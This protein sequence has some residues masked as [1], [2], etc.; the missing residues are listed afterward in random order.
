VT[1][2][3]VGMMDPNPLVA[4]RGIRFLKEKGIAITSG[5]LAAECLAINRPFVQWISHGT[6]WVIMKAGLSLDGRIAARSGNAGWI[7]N[8]ASRR[9]VHQLR[10]QVDAILIGIGTAINDDPSLTTR[11]PGR[12][13]RDPLRVVLDR[14]LRLSPGARMLR[15][16]SNV[17]TL[18]CCGP[19]P[20]PGRW[21]A[22]TEAGAEVVPLA[23]AGDGELDLRQVLVE[24]GRRQI[25]SLL[26]EG[27]SRIHGAFWSQKLVH[28]V[29]LF[30]GP[31]I[32]GADG[33]PLLTPL[34]IDQV[35]Q[36]PRLHHIRH[37][38]FGDDLMIEGL[39]V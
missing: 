23:L 34:A 11:L 3:V 8:A 9:H 27:G 12:G 17:G 2:V 29:N 15:Q 14:D 30:Y 5:V 31:L 24:L 32:L 21:Q 7:T 19:Q 35:E 10:D 1:R 18:I 28:Q 25:T 13:H 20:D 6:P 4:G 16:P 33:I 38:R 22:L 26:V 39:V 37:R 36:A